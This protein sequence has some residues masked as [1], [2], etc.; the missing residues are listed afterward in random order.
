M[1]KQKRDS[2]R[3]STG[4][5]GSGSKHKGRRKS[6]GRPRNDDGNRFES[7]GRRGE[8]RS[9]SDHKNSGH[10]NSGKSGDKKQGRQGKG[11]APFGGRA[12]SKRDHAHGKTES[13]RQEALQTHMVTCT[14]MDHEGLGLGKIDGE[15]RAIPGM[16]LGEKVEVQVNK[17]MKHATPKLVH[18][19]KASK[20]RVKPPCPYYEACGGCQLQHV[21]KNGHD[22]FKED[23]VRNLLGQY[24]PVNTIFAADNPFNYRNKSHTTFGR[25]RRGQTISGFYAAG[26][27]DIVEVAECMIQDQRANDIINTIRGMM[28]SFKM[29]PYDED[30]KEGFLRHILIKTAYKTGQVMV[31]IVAGTPVFPGKNN[32][33]KALKKAHP[34]VSTV[35]LNVNNR[36]TSMVLGDK[37]TVLHGKG[38]IIDELCGLQFELSSKSFYQ[39]NPPQTER[40]YNKAIEMAQLTGEETVIDAYC[41]IGTIGLIAGKQAKKV[42]GIEVNEDAV[43]DAIRNSRRNK[44][45]H[46]RFYQGDAGEFMVDMAASGDKADVVLMDPPRAGSDEKF[47]S[48]V[49]TLGPKRVVYVSCNPVTQQR[50]LKY[51]TDNGYEVVEIQPVDMFPQTYHVECCV[52]MKL[53]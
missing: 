21:N 11:Q 34:E 32:F 46:V 33:V 52:L 12:Q 10:K 4:P 3:K 47:L 20:D 23:V 31:V 41:G 22:K 5:S 17:Y 27:H 2:K 38:T 29:K 15:V 36:N 16:L 35:I 43:R 26:T 7:K 8:G 40:L 51:L 42:I 13:R 19:Q 28:K 14:G 30:F 1:T 6:P 18:V 44:M 25:G 9:G 49:V 39:I 48:S 50:D 45:K 53:K 24:G 37:E